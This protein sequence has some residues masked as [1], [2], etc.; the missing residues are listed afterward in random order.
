MR[1]SILLCTLCLLP[2]VL[3]AQPPAHDPGP[4]KEAMAKLA[5]LVGSWEGEGWIQMGPQTRHHSIGTETVESRLDGLILVIE[6]R[7]KDPETG[8]V[9]HHAFATVDW[10]EDA[11]QYRFRS[12]LSD[13][14]AADSTGHFEEGNFVWSPGSPPGSEIRY[15]I[16]ETEAGEWFEVGEMSRDGGKT[17]SQFFEMKLHRTGS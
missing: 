4:Q 13:G 9:V 14:R 16:H 10:D 1:A 2:L 17:W 5:F 8:K 11:G 6:G 15:V 12:L 3:C 7:H